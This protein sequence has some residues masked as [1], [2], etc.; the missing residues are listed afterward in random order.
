MGIG[1]FLGKKKSQIFPNNNSSPLSVSF[2]RQTGVNPK[3]FWGGKK[4]WGPPKKKLVFESNPCFFFI[5]GPRL[6]FNPEWAPPPTP[7]LNKK[8]RWGINLLKRLIFVFVF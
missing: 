4:T 8:E 5:F 2:F 3:K 1:L 6:V 7:F